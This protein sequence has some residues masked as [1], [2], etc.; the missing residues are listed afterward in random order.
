MATGDFEDLAIKAVLKGFGM[1]GKGVYKGA[2]LGVHKI[3]KA[4]KT[5]QEDTTKEGLTPP[6]EISQAE[7]EGFIFGKNLKLYI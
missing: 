7:L 2:K 1:L 5:L 4:R 3:S 6:K